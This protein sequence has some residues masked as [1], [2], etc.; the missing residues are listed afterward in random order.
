MHGYLRRKITYNLGRGGRSSSPSA[1]SNGGGTHK[2]G[3]TGG[4]FGLFTDHNSN[5]PSKK[6][7]QIVDEDGRWPVDKEYV[8]LGESEG[9]LCYQGWHVNERDE[10]VYRYTMR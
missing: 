9:W 5:Y 8:D 6:H 4:L 3:N 1:H 2:K 10:P 7:Y